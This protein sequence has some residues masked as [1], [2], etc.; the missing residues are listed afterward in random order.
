MTTRSH[1]RRSSMP[2]N[3]Q[4]ASSYNVLLQSLAAAMLFAFAALPGQGQQ[5]GRAVRVVVKEGKAEVGELPLDPTPHIEVG[6]AAGMFFGL[7]LDGSRITCTP[8]NSVLCSL[9]IDN[10]QLFPGFD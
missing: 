1:G 9:R 3:S 8:T 5:A 6:Q 2:R 4:A 10:Q 7:T